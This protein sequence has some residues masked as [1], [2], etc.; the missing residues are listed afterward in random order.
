MSSSFQIAV[1]GAGSIGSTFAFQLARAG[2]H[3]VTAI[4]RPGSRRLAQLQRDNGILNAKDERAEIRVL[5]TLDE[6]TPYDLVLVTLLDHQVEAVL[7]A[8]I[9]SA[10]RHVLFMFNSFNPERLQQALGTARCSFGMPFVQALIDPKGRLISTIGAGGQKCK[11]SD[12]RWVDLFVAAGL[13]AVLEPQMLLWLRCHAPLCVAFESVSVAAVR[14]GGGASWA[15]SSILAQGLQESFTMIQRLGYKLYPGGK[16]LLSSSP[17]FVPASV[18]WSMSR[19]KSFREL[20]ATGA[21]EC[22]ALVDVLA[23]AA[24]EVNP[25]VQIEKIRAMKPL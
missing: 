12:Q 21:G 6:Q 23:G 8:L 3:Q 9:R 15:E 14:R 13:P 4:A 11:L 18:L 10:A 25:P 1:L 16:A 22:R 2:G 17:A 5:D 24:L 20:L 7:P 19:I